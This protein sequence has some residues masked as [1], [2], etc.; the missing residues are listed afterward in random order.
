MSHYESRGSSLWH[1]SSH[2]RTLFHASLHD[3]SRLQ[4]LVEFQVFQSLGIFDSIAHS[5][6]V[7]AEFPAVCR[8]TCLATFLSFPTA[9]L[10]TDTLKSLPEMQ[11]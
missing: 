7:T 10:Q 3:S 8:P 1:C 6:D 4:L 5:I 11:V 2:L 9:S